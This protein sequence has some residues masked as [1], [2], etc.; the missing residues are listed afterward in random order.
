MH[1]VEQWKKLSKICEDKIVVC[2]KTA[3]LRCGNFSDL[4]SACYKVLTPVKITTERSDTDDDNKVIA[5]IPYVKGTSE[6]IARILRPH[7][8]CSL[9]W[10][11]HHLSI[12]EQEQFIE[13]NAQN[14]LPAMSEKLEERWSAELK[15]TSVA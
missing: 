2:E 12:H 6:R 13:Y 9:K 11:I 3:G 14:V 15:N 7:K 8:M 5:T 4:N 1:V 10:K